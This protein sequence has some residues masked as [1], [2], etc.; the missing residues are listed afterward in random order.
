[1]LVEQLRK[2]IE[3]KTYLENKRITEIIKGIEEAALALKDNPPAGPQFLTLDDKAAISLVMD[4]PPYDP[5]KNPELDSNDLEEGIGSLDSSS[6]FRQTYVN[7]DIL[8]DRIRVL[9]RGRRQITLKEIT[10]EIPVEKGLAEIITYFSI[11]SGFEKDNRSLIDVELKETVEY[12]M[13]GK[14]SEITLPKTIF[15]A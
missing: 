13:E 2:Y 4:R 15:L 12:E 6:L 7:P 1:M 5:P 3:L 9:L 14:R 11:A 8:Q 10:D